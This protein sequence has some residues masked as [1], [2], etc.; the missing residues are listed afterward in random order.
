MPDNERARAYRAAAM[1]HSRI[2]H[3]NDEI[4]RAQ[5]GPQPDGREFTAER[6]A[7][8]QAFIAANPDVAAYVSSQP[9]TNM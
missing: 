4:A 5:P 9:D 1:R 6:I 3:D 7:A 8:A 2:W